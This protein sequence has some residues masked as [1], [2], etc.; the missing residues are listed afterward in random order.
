MKYI[1]KGQKK[2]LKFRANKNVA[3]SNGL[4]TP[5]CCYVMDTTSKFK[6]AMETGRR[7]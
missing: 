2:K 5:A 1:G 3:W 4:S 7:A 6:M